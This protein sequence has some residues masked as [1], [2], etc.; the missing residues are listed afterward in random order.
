MMKAAVSGGAVQPNPG[1]GHVGQVNPECF[2][3]TTVDT[4]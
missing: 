2:E 4:I 1:F 3:T